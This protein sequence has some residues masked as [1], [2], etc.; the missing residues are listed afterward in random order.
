[1]IGRGFP[2]MKPTV[3]QLKYLRWWMETNGIILQV[4]AKVTHGS[5]G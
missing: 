5:N 1:M 4:T 3:I 2:T